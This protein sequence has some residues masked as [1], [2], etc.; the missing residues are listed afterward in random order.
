MQKE[1]VVKDYLIVKKIAK[2]EEQ[3]SNIIRIDIKM[4]E[5]FGGSFDLNKITDDNDKKIMIVEKIN[6]RIQSLLADKP[7]NEL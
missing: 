1:K 7:V 4:G 3:G 5:S 2:W 6:E